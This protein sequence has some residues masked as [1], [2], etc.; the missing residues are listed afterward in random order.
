MMKILTEEEEVQMKKTEEQAKELGLETMARQIAQE[1]YILNEENY[2]KFN[3]PDSAAKFESGNGDGVWGVPLTD[4]DNAIYKGT[5]KGVQFK[6]ILLNGAFTYPLA[7]GSIITVE[8]RGDSRP[9]LSYDWFDDVIK[10]SS[11]GEMTLKKIME[12]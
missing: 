8:T 2:L 12:E 3:L 6:V 1:E 5:E 9:V 10:K 11:G 4:A 7:W